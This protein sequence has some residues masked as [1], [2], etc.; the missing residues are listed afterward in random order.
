MKTNVQK[1]LETFR[2]KILKGEKLQD[3]KIEK[4]HQ[5]GVA[6]LLEGQQ[7]YTLHIYMLQHH[8]F[9]LVPSKN[10]PERYYIMTREL[11]RNPLKKAKYAWNI[12]GHGKANCR[13]GCIELHFDLFSAPI[14]M[15]IFPIESR[16]ANE[17]KLVA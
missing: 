15:S 4:S 8:E 10:D 7:N 9:Y 6:T 5:A 3:G 17:L 13:Q 11:S 2:F 16:V 14:Y 1:K 12:V